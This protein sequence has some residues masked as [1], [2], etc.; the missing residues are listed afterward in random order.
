MAT[1]LTPA[2]KNCSQQ[3]DVILNVK[4]KEIMKFGIVL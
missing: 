1:S 4:V 2:L 3:L